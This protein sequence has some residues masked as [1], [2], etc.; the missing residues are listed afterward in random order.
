MMATTISRPFIKRPRM[1][2]NMP[3]PMPKRCESIEPSSMPP[4]KMPMPRMMLPRR[5]ELCVFALAAAAFDFAFAAGAFLSR[6]LAS[7]DGAYEEPL[8]ETDLLV[9]ALFVAPAAG[10]FGAG[11]DFGMLIFAPPLA[12]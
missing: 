6:L 5:L 12:A 3:L 4:A 11:A 10:A 7:L 2:A 1:S 8:P 9:L